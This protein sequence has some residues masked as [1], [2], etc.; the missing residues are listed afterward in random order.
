MTHL[1][2]HSFIFL[3]FAKPSAVVSFLAAL[4]AEAVIMI[5]IL[6]PGKATSQKNR[7][8]CEALRDF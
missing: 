8:A 5:P 4:P 6:L 3:P 2:R 7:E 1:I